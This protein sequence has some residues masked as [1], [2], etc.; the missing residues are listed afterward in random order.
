[1]L[2]SG[3]LQQQRH[4]WKLSRIFRVEPKNMEIFDNFAFFH[5]SHLFFIF[6]F[7]SFSVVRA[8]AKTENKSKSSYC[9]MTIFLN[10]K[11]ISGPR[12]TVLFFFFQSFFPFF[13]FSVVRPKPPTTAVVKG[14]SQIH[15]DGLTFVP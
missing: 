12:L 15:R 3:I 13:S 1:M 2:S 6:S 8:D 10:E 5:F 7:F 14:C 4:P 11:S 9:K